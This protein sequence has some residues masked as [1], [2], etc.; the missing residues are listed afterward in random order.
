MSTLK[1]LV[2]S[3]TRWIA[4]TCFLNRSSIRSIGNKETFSTSIYTFPLQNKHKTADHCTFLEWLKFTQ[5]EHQNQV[6]TVEHNQSV[7]ASK[8][9]FKNNVRIGE[10][11]GSKIP[12]LLG[13]VKSIISVLNY[14]NQPT[15][16]RQNPFQ[17]PPVIP[18]NSQKSIRKK[19]KKLQKALSSGHVTWTHYPKC[20][21]FFP[22]FCNWS[23]SNSWSISKKEKKKKVLFVAINDE[24]SNSMEGKLLLKFHEK[25]GLELLTQRRPWR[26][27]VAGIDFACDHRRLVNRRDG[28]RDGR[29]FGRIVLF[30]P[31]ICGETD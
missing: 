1:H 5:F 29:W 12:S 31:T 18:S 16:I 23:K 17:E 10:Q 14:M 19:K 25:E 9:N 8:H 21:N 28:R 20:K 27:R 11:R 3:I 13:N 4:A 6:P 7:D 26:L 2:N 15:K 22:K 24:E 30:L